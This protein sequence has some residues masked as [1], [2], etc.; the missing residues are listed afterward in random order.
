M[1]SKTTF[2]R[3]ALVAVAALG[4]GTVST[5]AANASY[6]YASTAT[7]STYTT[8]FSVN[9]SSFTI[10][11]TGTPYA[12]AEITTTGEAGE[13]HSLFTG[14]TVKATVVSWPTAIDS[15]TA[16]SDLE[17]FEP[18]AVS[19]STGAAT[20]TTTGDGV[21]GTS[22]TSL[23]LSVRRF[24][25]DAATGTDGGSENTTT[26][27][28]YLLGIRNVSGKAL[29]KGTYTV[30]L[31]LLKSGNVIQRSLVKVTFV[32][33]KVDSG[34][35][36][37]VAT[38]GVQT[39]GSALGL[40]S[41]SYVR[42]TLTDANG[43]LVRE[44]NNAQPSLSVTIKDVNDANSTTVTMVDTAA[45]ADA[46]DAVALNGV[47]G[48]SGTVN[49]SSATGAATVIARYGSASA[50]AS[51]TVNG[52]TSSGYGHSTISAT[53]KVASSNNYL[54][55]LTTKT[56]TSTITV[57]T[58][59]GAATAK[60]GSTVYYS[61][62]YTAA[63]NTVG[64]VTADMSPTAGVLTKAITD[65]NGQATAT[66]TNANPLNGCIA[67]ITWSGLGSITD[68][69]SSTAGD[70]AGLLSRAVKWQSPVAT[71]VLSDPSADIQALLLS[72]NKVT[73][74]VLDQFSQPVVGKT[75]TFTM[76]GANKPTAGLAS[77]V[78]DNEAVAEAE[79]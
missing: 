79:P 66:V 68:Y 33:D 5:V 31:D 48:G 20:G 59:V 53:G 49:S 15:T 70:Q 27:G 41:T 58:A 46:V 4:L 7:E 13:A 16:A 76:S 74:T 78:T 19:D 30:R 17:F 62:A 72:T 37:S 36:L 24:G 9:A 22:N 63:A 38:K 28:T 23:D 18:T 14:E 12:V 32:S 73:W 2:K 44:D 64:C 8:G 21:I 69:D 6:T 52:A 43:G 42:A 1:S 3:I 26:L 50:T 56:A 10:V 55:P 35:K 45:G 60:T 57:Y 47:Y 29:D 67:T 25:A 11:G 61:V 51:L 39:A 34:A 65:S 77:Q 75:A 40:S 71:T 54:V